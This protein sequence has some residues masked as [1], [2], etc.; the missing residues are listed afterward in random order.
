MDFFV[1]EDI[2]K[3]IMNYKL[4]IYLLFFSDVIYSNQLLL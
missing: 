1:K 4:K 2:F 3:L